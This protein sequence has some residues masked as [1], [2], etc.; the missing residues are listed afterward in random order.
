MKKLGMSYEGEFKQHIWMR[1]NFEDLMYYGMT[2]QDYDQ[3]QN[4][5]A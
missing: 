5:Q 3:M 2:K 1:G 4:R